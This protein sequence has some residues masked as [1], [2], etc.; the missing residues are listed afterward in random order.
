MEHP[1][2]LLAHFK[3]KGFKLSSNQSRALKQELT[4]LKDKQQTQNEAG[5]VYGLPCGDC[6][7]MYVGETGRQVKDRMREHQNDVTKGKAVSKVFLIMY[8]K[9]DIALT[10]KMSRSL[11]RALM[12]KPAYIWRASTQS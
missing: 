2:E 8:L 3:H 12:S 1:N 10:L 6:S 11:T 4:H 9:L 7:A 5:V